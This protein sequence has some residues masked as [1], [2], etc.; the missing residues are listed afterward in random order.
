M[1]DVFL[2]FRTVTLYSQTQTL[3]VKKVWFQS[4]FRVYCECFN[5]SP[6]TFNLEQKSTQ[7][8]MKE[9]LYV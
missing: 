8:L 3:T 7:E 9:E 6:I 4:C 1:L 2:L 5:I